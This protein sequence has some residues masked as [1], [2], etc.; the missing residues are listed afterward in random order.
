MFSVYIRQSLIQLHTPGRDAGPRGRRFDPRNI[1]VQRAGGS[2]CRLQRLADRSR[3]PRSW[4]GGI[5]A[6]R[7]PCCGHASSPNC[8]TP[9]PSTCPSRRRKRRRSRQ[10]AFRPVHATSAYRTPR[11]TGVTR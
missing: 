4:R 5:G 3:S 9:A 1:G 2:A 8:A 10:G 11:S 7:S 6:V